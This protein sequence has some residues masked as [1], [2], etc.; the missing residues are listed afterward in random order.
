MLRRRS[1]LLVGLFGLSWAL[2]AFGL[3]RG[4]YRPIIRFDFYS[5]NL[6]LS[7]KDWRDFIHPDVYKKYLGKAGSYFNTSYFQGDIDK[8][9]RDVS[10]EEVH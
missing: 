3:R 10:A 9:D 8:V 4:N 6:G 1:F 7:F 2:G 5:F